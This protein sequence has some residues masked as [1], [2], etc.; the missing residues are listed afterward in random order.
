[1]TKPEAQ[2]IVD[3]VKAGKRHKSGHYHYGY[4]YF[5]YEK[6]EKCFKYKTE[7]LAMNIYEPTIEIENLSEEEFLEKLMKYYEYNKVVRELT[8]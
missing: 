4:M 7:D 5:W 2:I 6:P 3:I 1:M 8:E